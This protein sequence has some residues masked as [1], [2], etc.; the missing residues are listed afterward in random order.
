MVLLTSMY[1]L[2]PTFLTLLT[3][4][5]P[6]KTVVQDVDFLK[7]FPAIADNMHI[8]GLVL[9]TFTGKLKQVV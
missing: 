6:E 5:S 2:L 9:D 8:V 7:S 1:S 4:I 3:G